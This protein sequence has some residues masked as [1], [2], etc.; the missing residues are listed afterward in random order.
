MDRRRYRVVSWDRCVTRGSPRR[1]A[2]LHRSAGGT[3]LQ[4]CCR[5]GSDLAIYSLSGLADV[6]NSVIG[7]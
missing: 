7:K 1:I 4:G 2:H 5:L 6:S 3:T